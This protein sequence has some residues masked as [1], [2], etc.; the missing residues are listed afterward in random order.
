VVPGLD[1]PAAVLDPFPGMSVHAVVAL[2]P[3]GVPGALTELL[4]P[5]GPGRPAQLAGLPAS[6][7]ADRPVAGDR[8]AELT[9]ARTPSGLLIVACIGRTGSWPA[10]AGCA[11]QVEAV[12]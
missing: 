12:R 7:Y 3:H 6:A 5:L 8:I 11:D 4:G 1:G 9:V 2:A 10:A